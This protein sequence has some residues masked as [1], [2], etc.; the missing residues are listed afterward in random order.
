MVAPAHLVYLSI[1]VIF[2]AVADHVNLSLM[3]N[4]KENQQGHGS[5]L[6]CNKLQPFNGD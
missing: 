4:Y 2:P 1:Q 6:L 5:Q 3:F